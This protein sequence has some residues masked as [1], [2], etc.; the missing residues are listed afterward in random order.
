HRADSSQARRRG[1]DA[2]HRARHRLLPAVSR[3]RS[4]TLAGRIAAIHTVGTLLALAAVIAA[5]TVTVTVLLNRRADR[6]LRDIAGRAAALSDGQEAATFGTV[7]IERELDE[8][9]PA[10][11]RVEIR[12]DTGRILAATGPA[13]EL[14]ISEAG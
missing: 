9:R 12:D 10:T 11:T 3:M 4:R 2:A 7:W 13:L 5:T 8:L 6:T 1:P 14:P